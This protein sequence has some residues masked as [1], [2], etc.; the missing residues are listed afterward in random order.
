MTHYSVTPNFIHGAIELEATERGLLPHR[1][2]SSIRKQF[3][4]PQLMAMERQPSG[5]R[6]I[7][8]TTSQNITLETCH[9]RLTYLDSGRPTARIDV[10]VDDKLILSEET[11][12]GKTIAVNFVSGQTETTEA[13]NHLCFLENLPATNKKVEFWLPY[14]EDVEIIAIHADATITP[15]EPGTRW[16]NYGSSISQG[17][18][19]ASPSGIWPARVAHAKQLDLLNLGFGGSAMLD[20]FIARL[21]RDTPAELITLEV[22]INIVNSD[23]MRLRTFN[24]ALHGFLDTIRG[25][26][27]STPLYV[28]SPFYCGIH[29]AT[30]GP[31]AFDSSS[32]GSGQIRFIATGEDTS[33]GRLTLEVIRSAVAEIVDHRADENLHHINGAEIFS[34]ADAAEHPLPDNLHPDAASH[35]IIAGRVEKQL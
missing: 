32:F 21:I 4:D 22:G 11:T 13:G 1:L 30:P 31:G 10:L 15:V 29:E 28:I 33:N 6:V 5:V 12:G 20:P 34:A 19:A 23:A 2:P 24:A 9:S 8:H 16:I 18:N 7:F 35:E 3:P 14:N 26:H 17:S 27:P 25:G